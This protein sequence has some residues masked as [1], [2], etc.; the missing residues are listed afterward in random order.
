MADS[1]FLTRVVVQDYKSIA[2][3]DIAPS[4]YSI[5]VGP[6]GAGKSNFLNALRLVADGLR[7]SL[8]VALSSQGG[9]DSVVRRSEDIESFGIR[10]DCDL[11]E[12]SAC[13]AFTV[14]ALEAGEFKVVREEC[15]VKPDGNELG[16]AHYSI[17]HGSVKRCSVPHPPRPSEFRLYLPRWAETQE[18][19]PLHQALSGMAFYNFSPDAIRRPPPMRPSKML[20]RDGSNLATVL[21]FL[22]RRYPE[23]KEIVE[24]Y[25]GCVVSGFNRLSQARVGSNQILEFWHQADGQHDPKRFYA[26]EMSDGALRLLGILV[27]LFQR[28][29]RE[30]GDPIPRLI[31]IE[32]PENA[33]D[34]SV[35]E[36]LGDVFMHAADDTQVIVTSHNTELLDHREVT[37]TSIITVGSERGQ[38]RIAPINDVDRSL[39]LDRTCTAGQLLRMSRLH[40]ET[41]GPEQRPYRPPLFDFLP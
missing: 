35:L 27:A 15:L 11:G 16:A 36:F 13:Y 9:A 30:G 4:Q 10:V 1:R 24:R 12:G 41:P 26:S 14:Q 17:E 40:Y 25:F 21:T 2:S 22:E 39:M 3:C 18:F 34:P 31:G 33:M 32:E 8:D 5:L 7:D 19:F 29:D 20:I 6:T 28:I 37:D 38:T 23:L